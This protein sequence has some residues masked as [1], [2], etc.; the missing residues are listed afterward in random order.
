MTVT[1]TTAAAAGTVGV[2][3]VAEAGSS[4]NVDGP[5]GHHALTEGDSFRP[6]PAAGDP[7]AA[8]TLPHWDPRMALMPPLSCRSEVSWSE[9]G[10][11][12]GLDWLRREP[13]DG[14]LG[15]G[16]GRRA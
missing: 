2:I 12:D 16:F 6:P 15:A 11:L 5:V 10:D 14:S 7:A 4:G 9:A 1:T 13:V 3:T 8:T